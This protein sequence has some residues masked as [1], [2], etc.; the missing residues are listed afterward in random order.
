[1]YHGISKPAVHYAKENKHV[2]KTIAS[3]PNISQANI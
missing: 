3:L 2:G 1:M